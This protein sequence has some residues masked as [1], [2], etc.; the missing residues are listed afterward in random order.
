MALSNF[1]D[2][3]TLVA[4]SWFN[5]IDVL[6]QTIFDGVATK[7]AARAALTSDAPISVAQGGTG[8][9]TVVGAHTNLDT[10]GLSLVNTFTDRQIIS[11]A[12]PT[13]SLI[14]SD[15]AVDNRL[16][17]VVINNG[18]LYFRI[19]SDSYASA[20]SFFTIQRTGMVINSVAIGGTSVSVSGNFIAQT[21]TVNGLAT[22]A[23]GQ[24]KFP[25]VQNVSS[26]FNTLDDYVKGTFTAIMTA[27]TSG[28]I[29]V[30][31]N[32]CFYTKVGNQKFLTGYLQVA[33][34][35]APTGILT[36]SGFPV[37]LNASALSAIS[38]YAHGLVGLTTESL[39]GYISSNK[40]YLFTFS[41]GVRGNALA[42]N[43]QIGSIISFSASYI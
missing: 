1:V 20:S 13:F 23:G 41:S 34:I 39:Q 3:V 18:I 24:L 21:L 35:S 32:T 17:E 11:N 30:S 38:V 36:I 5:S 22:L 16:W 42:S 28:A 7:A 12:V 15:A 33:A 8:A 37:A 10:P 40:L 31:A 26:D 43:L 29:S 27:E 6:W 2:K 4:T 14:E 9:T 25:A 19:T